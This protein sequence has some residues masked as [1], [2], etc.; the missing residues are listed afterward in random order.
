MPSSTADTAGASRFRWC[1]DDTIPVSRK[2]VNRFPH[3]V[4]DVRLKF[5]ATHTMPGWLQVSPRPTLQ[6]LFLLQVMY[7]FRDA[8][9]YRLNVYC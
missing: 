4:L 7:P 6:L 5:P 8:M 3:V 1:R 9:R 2:D